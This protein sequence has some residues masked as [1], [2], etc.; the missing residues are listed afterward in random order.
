M[1]D[2]DQSNPK[3]TYINICQNSVGRIRRDVT[4]VEYAGLYTSGIETCFVIVIIGEQG[5]SMI[6]N[7]GKIAEADIDKEFQHIGPVI[8]WTLAY[9]PS[10]PYYAPGALES[11]VARVP[12]RFEK[13]G[14]AIKQKIERGF[15]AVDRNGTIETIN[16]LSSVAIFTDVFFEIRQKINIVNDFFTDPAAKSSLA[17]DL[18][19]D[20]N[21][22]C[23][24]PE[25]K[26]DPV[27]AKLFRMFPIGGPALDHIFSL[28]QEIEAFLMGKQAAN[29]LKEKGNVFF[30]T[31]NYEQALNYYEQA[32]EKFYPFKEAW[33]NKAKTLFKLNQFEH[34]LAAAK[35]AQEIDPTWSP[36][37]FIIKNIS[38]KLT[39]SSCLESVEV[40]I[41]A[42]DLAQVA[43]QS[44][45]PIYGVLSTIPENVPTITTDALPINSTI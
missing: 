4:P 18:Q 29:E 40:K 30:K 33:L 37:S 38:L 12:A 39:T 32:I 22:F 11:I 6:H 24:L 3:S 13:Y 2:E 1:Y 35:K 21:T 26:V 25:L 42:S 41:E 43:K 34:A 8:S 23:A 27:K 5:V 28:K 31:G 14:I 17:A 16:P 36:A 9:N 44:G 19:F 15:V 20:G 45:S 10:S 7:S